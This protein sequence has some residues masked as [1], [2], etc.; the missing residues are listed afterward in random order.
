MNSTRSFEIFK[1]LGVVDHTDVH[2]VEIT[3]FEQKEI[4]DVLIPTAMIE[5]LPLFLHYI[6]YKI[7]YFA[8]VDYLVHH[9]EV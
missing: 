9:A 8:L 1:I 2:L 4:D 5:F 3:L 7:N 6:G